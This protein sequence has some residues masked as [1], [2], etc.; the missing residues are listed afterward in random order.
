MKLIFQLSLM[1]MLMLITRSRM[2]IHKDHHIIKSPPTKR[3]DIEVT[4][5]VRTEPDIYASDT[6]VGDIQANDDYQ[7]TYEEMDIKE[8]TPPS[9]P[10]P[11]PPEPSPEV[12]EESE[13]EPEPYEPKFFENF[14][15]EEEQDFAR[16]QTELRQRIGV[17]KALEEKYS[18]DR[19]VPVTF[20]ELN[21][22]ILVFEELLDLRQMSQ[23]F[24]RNHDDYLQ[25]LRE[26]SGEEE[27]EMMEDDGMEN[28][29]ENPWEDEHHEL[30]DDDEFV[31]EDSDEHE[32]EEEHEHEHE[33]EDEYEH[34]EEH[35]GEHHEEDHEHHH[36]NLDEWDHSSHDAEDE[37][38]IGD[39]DSDEDHFHESPHDEFVEH[40]A[41]KI[42]EN[43]HHEEDE[44]NTGDDVIADS[45][46]LHDLMDKA[47]HHEPE[48][49]SPNLSDLTYE[50]QEIKKTQTHETLNDEI[51]VI[52]GLQILFQKLF[53]V[54]PD[55]KEYLAG[56]TS[57][58]HDKVDE[59][60]GI[61]HDYM[62]E[63]TYEKD[64]L[65]EELA[66][67]IKNIGLMPKSKQSILKFFDLTSKYDL[68]GIKLHASDYVCQLK[69]QA[70]GHKTN[71]FT[72]KME[73]IFKDMK[74]ITS[75]LIAIEHQSEK[76]DNRINALLMNYDEIQF[77]DKYDIAVTFLPS[78]IDA[79]NLVSVKLNEARE[80]LRAMPTIKTF[81]EEAVDSFDECAEGESMD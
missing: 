75:G 10:S 50:S 17:L 3:F 71:A 68:I 2:L 26:T 58:D 12:E 16:D 78:L 11:P 54:V 9:E 24:G 21:D 38:D 43:L 25:E 73:I 20:N 69:D 23:D 41:E 31:N 5:D 33:H 81:V 13:P 37:W 28:E 52:E 56:V 27:D 32:H 4:N 15:P 61:I 45:D 64:H 22:I 36:S 57:Q 47:Y 51:V 79:K 44:L 74:N 14:F 18:E 35:E 63:Y 19:Y 7:D 72:H 59:L 62:E 29:E 65:H 42:V 8:R 53:M 46:V 80:I 67:L 49:E 6:D 60:F 30:P 1:S 70:I 66:Y 48:T 34:E 76:I 77:L 55:D 39:G 40:E